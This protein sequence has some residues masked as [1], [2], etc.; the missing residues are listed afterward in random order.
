MSDTPDERRDHLSAIREA[1]GH[2]LLNGLGLGCVL[3]SC[4]EKE[5]VTKVTVVEKEEDVIAL[6]APHYQERYGDRL[7]VVHADAFEYKPP[8]GVRYGMVW[9]DIWPNM[10]A[11]NLPEMHRLHRKYGRRTEWQGSWGRAYIES[12]LP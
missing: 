11:D 5:G 10:C 8:K 4:L 9:H 7:E 2:V 6:V 1:K 12:R 3:Q